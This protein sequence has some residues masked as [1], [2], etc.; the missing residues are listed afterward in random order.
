MELFDLVK[1]LETIAPPDLA[2]DFDHGKIGLIVPGY[3]KVNKVATAL[4]P[5][6]FVIER[7]IDMHAEALVVHHTLIWN[8]VTALTSDMAGVLKLLLENDISLYS[9][10]TNYDRAPGGVNETL[11]DLLGL[12]DTVAVDLCRAGIV[13]TQSLADFAASASKALGADV[14]VVGRLNKEVSTVV[15]A[16][17]SA[18]REALPIAKQLNADVLV[19]SELRHDVIRDRGNVALVSAPHYFTEAPSM[20]RLAERL[21]SKNVRAEFVDDPPELKVIRP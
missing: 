1:L 16:A 10:H 12:K 3:H 17:G 20:K 19:S 11:A 2:E 5:T 15:T 6:P 14:E 8:P 7:A 4:D 21:N 13:E 18:F 9:M